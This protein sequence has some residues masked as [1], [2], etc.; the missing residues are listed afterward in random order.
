M[1]EK[2][3]IDTSAQKLELHRALEKARAEGN[4]RKKLE[5]HT[6]L[7]NLYIADEKWY[8][9]AAV[10]GEAAVQG[11]WKGGA[12][13]MGLPVDL[14]NLIVGL[15]E[16][17]VRKVLDAAGFEIDSGLKDSKLMS[18]KP[19]LGSAQTTEI[20]NNLG[21][22]TEYDKTRA[23]TAIIGR[24]AEEVGMSA[25]IAGV[26]ARGA[27]KPVQFL[28]KEAGIAV[29]AGTGAATAQQLFPGSMG[30]EI[31]G[32]LVG[33][34]T[35]LTATTIMK[36]AGAK[37]GAVEA[38]NLFFRAEA[39]QKEIAGNILYQKLGSEKSAK[40]LADIKAGK[41]IKLF[42]EE[43]EASKFPRT[44][45]QIT[46]EPELIV[47]RQQLEGSEV[48]IQVVDAIQQTKLARLLELENNFIKNIK[49][50]DYSI[51]ST[52][53]AVENRVNHIT[54]YLDKRLNLAQQTAANK[55]QAI[56]PNMTREQASALLRR[57][58]DEAL[59]DALNLEQKMW[60]TIDGT[61][62]GDIISTGAAA[63]LNN[64]LKTT[65][66]KNVPKILYDLAGD[67][68]LVKAG[69][70]EVK[71]TQEPIGPKLGTR[72]I[73]V[74]PTGS[75]LTNK[76]PISEIV[77]LRTRIRD[78]IRGE[79]SKANPS[80]EKLQSLNDLLGGVDESFMDVGNPKNI[81]EVTQAI[82]FSDSLQNN[83]YS[84]QTG[85]IL[86]YDAKGKLKV[87]PESTFNKL[88]QQGEEGGVATRDVNKIIAQDSAGIQEGLRNRFSQLAV[89][90]K[91]DKNLRDKFIKNN[92][93]IL[94]E[95]PLLK[96]QFL[97]ANESL[98]IVEQAQKNYKTARYDI[99]KYRLE[100][101][102]SDGG[103][104]LSA[105]GIVTRI[106]NS[107]DPVKDIN[108]IIKLS[109][110]DETGA[111]L[112]GLQNETTD[113]IFNQI[114]TKEIIVG[115]KPQTVPDIK[116][117]NK[118]IKKNDEALRVLYGDDGFKTIQ[119][120]Q[121]VLKDIDNV[122]ISGG[123]DDLEV[124]ARNNVFVSSVGRI[125]GTKVAA[126][127]GGPALVFAGIGG[128]LA[129]M[130]IS[131]KSTREIKAL[132]GKAFTD[133]DFATDLLKPYVDKQQEIVSKSIN[134]YLV[135]A[136]GEKVREE[137]K[138]EISVE[139]PNADIDETGTIQPKE[140]P[141]SG[142]TSINP[143]SDR[144]ANAGVMPNPV[145]MMPTP[146]ANTG[147]TGRVNEKTASML[148]P[149]DKIFTPDTFAA[150]GG[151][152]NAHKQIQRVA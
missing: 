67:K 103:Q 11:L 58:I 102:A 45:D 73:S 31:T 40:L 108:K 23:S 127:T 95:F 94:N 44:L 110:R 89:D 3:T 116:Q 141:V 49:K 15:G 46:A 20:L 60:G 91:V 137:I 142:R 149:N 9:T 79:N 22:K 87:I 92:D 39:R 129:N 37:T 121:S 144:F 30:A 128:R 5:L 32:Q 119:E 18:K 74:E 28:G 100:T 36:Y 120:F 12:Q 14:T 76:E 48:G 75:I 93:E 82:N 98:N 41:K 8:E 4:E 123:M 43:I 26:V 33:G 53:S 80:K 34:F 1:A 97:D 52:I 16:T 69:L 117:L 106:F 13:T 133:L 124:I 72:E 109:A 10:R 145:G 90:G 114:K 125:L 66:P 77:N 131:K 47:L 115:G 101:L 61:I 139:F 63:I 88:I 25:P 86:G 21:I 17:G 68:N 81:N 24:I 136:F 38:F 62:N 29:A 56:N 152:M 71:T 151:I 83:Y 64:Q 78:E 50:K 19:F 148:F 7:Q 146:T 134:S 6:Q 51:E 84:G 122:I 140:V 132:L 59:Q 104:T 126:A 85:Q 135:N 57:E 107:K 138:P 35:P 2:D 147:P 105:K 70:K 55:I 65:D 112:N 118:F 96:Q 113:F 54:N 130:L 99:D 42:G 143:A 27:A 150:Q 111:A